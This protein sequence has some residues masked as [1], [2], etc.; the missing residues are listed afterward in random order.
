MVVHVMDANH[1]HRSFLLALPP[2][3]ERHTGVNIAANIKKIFESFGIDTKRIGYFMADN[4]DNNDTCIRDLSISLEFQEYHRRLRCMGHIINLVAC[5]VLF[6][7]NPDAFEEE[8]QADEELVTQL[9]LWR[10]IG[11]VANYIIL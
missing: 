1:Q 9:K 11:P 8:I 7:V 2:Q 5:M 4:A 6:G 3:D 10:K